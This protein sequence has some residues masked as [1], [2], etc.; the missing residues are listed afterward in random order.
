MLFLAAVT[1]PEG[2]QTPPMITADGQVFSAP[3]SVTMSTCDFAPPE[4]PPP[5]P[6]PPPA[7]VL[8]ANRAP[9]EVVVVE[10]VRD[11]APQASPRS[12]AALVDAPS[13]ASPAPESSAPS[14]NAARLG[15]ESVPSFSAA[16]AFSPSVA[17]SVE[18]RIEP[19]HTRRQPWLGAQLDVG[20]PD[21]VGA[22]AMVM[23]TDWLRVQVGGSWNGASRG[24]R[25]GLVALPFPSFFQSVRPTVSI[26]GGYAFDTT[27]Q[28]LIDLAQDPALKAALAKVSVLHATGQLG[29]E[30]GS[31]YF[32]FFLRGGLSYVDVQLASYQGESAALEGLALHGLFPSGKLGFLVCFL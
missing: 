7:Q 15:D 14:R 29:L 24:L 10:R 21:G 32:S 28:W 1:A 26:E 22:S 19:V 9:R 2:W 5:E 20:F 25:A 31:K 11:L 8:S 17:P 27:S 30:F 13:R 16:A 23:P 18:R 6:T 4:A 3:A 12:T